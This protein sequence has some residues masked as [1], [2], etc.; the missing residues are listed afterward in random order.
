MPKTGQ[1]SGQGRQD[2]TTAQPERR[3]TGKA[4]WHKTTPG[5]TATGRT[6]QYEATGPTQDNTRQGKTKQTAMF[7]NLK[8]RLQEV[9]SS[10]GKRGALGEGDVDAALREVR[11]ALLDADVAL[12]VVRTFLEK[13]REKA[14]GSEVVK[15]VRP[16]Q[17]V[18]KIV[19]DA[20]VEMLGTEPAPLHIDANP[21][22]VFLLAGLQGS[23]KTTTAGK[24]ALRLRTRERKKVMVASLDVSRPA[25]R[26][27]L[28][29]LGEQAGVEVLDEA[30]RETPKTI[31][32][33]ALTAAKREGIDV[34]ILDT[35]GRIT[36]DDALMKE[37][38]EIKKATKPH[39]VLLVADAMT[40]QDAVVTADAFNKAVSITG[41]ILTRLDGDARGGA[42]LS[43]RQVTGCPIKL[44]GVGEKQDALEEF[45][46]ARLA[47][48]ILDMGDV[49][50]LVE[51]ASETIEAE[52]AERLAK[53][54]AK[55]KFDMNDLLSQLRQ[56]RKMGGLGGIMGMLPGLGKIKKQIDAAGL[57]ESL[58]NR[59][60]AIILSMTT[61][62]RAHSGLLNASRRR[63]IAQGSGTSV[64]EVNRLVKQQHDM[65]RM[66][67]RFGGKSGRAAMQSLMSGGMPPG[68]G[69]GMAPGMTPGQLPD[70]SKGLPGDISGGMPDGMAGGMPG[71]MPGGLPGGLSGGFPGGLP[72]SPPGAGGAGGGRK[73]RSA[74]KKR[75]KKR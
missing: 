51:K 64:Q 42:A 59:Q 20:L 4:A 35:A 5:Q 18:I 58:I 53:R 34:L 8:D 67:K 24:L 17:Q 40:G 68:M 61:K 33:R 14:V 37:L 21:P 10:L 54:M 65:A 44:A 12:P 2:G 50:A 29:V 41:I 32:K 22:T 47:G 73:S 66:M 26:E 69:Q 45:D 49:V 25:A 1:R 31:A 55:G 27:Q 3:E 52:E 19:N 46:P 9:F 7:D 36:I 75:R 62:E 57:D 39:E 71:G 28:R 23:G 48:R 70:M 43:M 16:D 30:E 60:E 74:T 72:G 13:V 11:L 63:R 38:R 15:S 6:G 56:I